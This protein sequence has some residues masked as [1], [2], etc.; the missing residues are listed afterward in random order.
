MAT[1]ER[2]ITFGVVLLTVIADAGSA[3]AREE[4][5]REFRKTVPLASGGTF[6]IDHSRG[7][8]TIRTQPIKEIEIRAIIRCSADT[9]D[10]ARTYAD[11][12]RIRVDEGSGKVAVRTEY[13]E[14]NR[15]GWFWNWLSNMN[16]SFG[17]D[18]DIVVPETSPVEVHNRFGWVSAEGLPTGSVI[19]NANGRVR[20]R[21]GRGRQRIENRF[22]EVEVQG[23]DGD[24][25][26]RNA[27][28]RV[29]ASDITGTLE[30]SDRFGEVRINNAQ[31]GAR[32]DSQNGN[33]GIDS[34]GSTVSV[35]NSFGPV[36][37]WE[38]KGDLTVMNQN[39]DIDAQGIAGSANL[40]T[41]FARVHVASI[42]KGLTVQAHNSAVTGDTVGESAGVETSFADVDLHD[43]KGGARIS[44]ENS[45]IRLSGIGGEVFAKTSFAVVAVSDTAGPITV[46]NQK[47][48][49]TVEVRQGVRCQ[50][51][52]VQTS[53]API[54]VAL[55]AG[56][57]YNVT[58]RTSFGSI[59]SE[60]EMT[61]IGDVSPDAVSGQIAGGGCELRLMDQN[62]NI[63][64][65][66]QLGLRRIAHLR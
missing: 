5:T 1:R 30:I 47:G 29:T 64:I 59:H 26:V 48:S 66:K 51:I 23:N 60:H 58:A 56:A 4:Y 27:N 45:G 10:D 62:G 13:P 42:G 50:P 14:F 57:G 53:F 37:A 33:V 34:A 19:I 12:V 38:V 28:G 63:D 35:A 21:G 65:S 32:V 49:V 20:F 55:P 25:T 6:R 8:I 40:H 43:V 7:S 16:I 3:A 61:I 15:G 24:V 46:E 39:G 2:L 36:R 31:R 18:Y 52:A 44:A 41:S 22:G 11:Q 9:S 17:A 54:R